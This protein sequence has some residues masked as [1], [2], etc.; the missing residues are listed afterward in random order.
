M[1]RSAKQESHNVGI[2]RIDSGQLRLTRRIPRFTRSPGLLLQW[3]ESFWAS[4][5]PEPNAEPTY[6]LPR[7]YRTSAFQEYEV[8]LLKQKESDHNWRGPVQL[9][10]QG[11]RTDNPHSAEQARQPNLQELLRKIRFGQRQA[12]NSLWTQDGYSGPKGTSDKA[13]TNWAY[14]PLAHWQGGSEAAY[15]P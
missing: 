10:W 6:W 5:S 9:A 2:L 13:N 14:D 7:I 12:L 1:Q 4:K 3:N 11:T 15:Q 8:C